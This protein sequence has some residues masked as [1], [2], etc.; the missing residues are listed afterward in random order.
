MR[1]KLLCLT[2][3]V[4][5]MVG[6]IPQ[7]ISTEAQAASG[8]TLYVSQSGQDS[9]DGTLESP[10]KTLNAARE[11]VRLLK[12]SGKGD[13]A[14]VYIRGG[15]YHLN[16][17]FILNELDSNT[18]FVAYD[19]EQVSIKGSTVLD[20]SRFRKV[21]DNEVLSHFPDHKVA[22]K[23]LQYNLNTHGIKQKPMNY[24]GSNNPSWVPEGYH[25]QELVVNDNRQ[26]VARYPNSGYTPVYGAPDW[27]TKGSTAQDSVGMS[28]R[29]TE[30]Q[31]RHWDKADRAMI[32]G[33]FVNGWQ[34][35]TLTI[36][37]V[38][39]FTNT[40]MANE[41][42]TS[43][44][45][46]N[47]SGSGARFY[48]FNLLEEL[49]TSGEYYVDADKGILYLYPSETFETDKIELTT[50][51]QPL[52]RVTGAKNITFSGINFLNGNNQGITITKCDNVCVRDGS[53]KNM[54]R[55]A[56][57]ISNSTNSGIDHMEIKHVRGGVYIT[58]CG[59]RKTLTPANCYCKN[60]KIS[61]YA[62]VAYT[63]A[64]RITD[65]VG[66][67][68]SN[69]EI[70][71][72]DHLAITFGGNEHIIEY[73]DIHD[74]LRCT[75]DAGAIYTGK[76]W[77][78]RGHKVRYNYIHD[79]KN[80]MNGVGS[81]CVGIYFDDGFCSADVYGNIIEDFPGIG[82][83]VSGG[84]D[85]NVYNNIIGSTKQAILAQKRFKEGTN[86]KTLDG[87]KQLTD[88]SVE[89]SVANYWQTNV[90]KTEYP[91]L[92]TILDDESKILLPTGNSIYNNISLNKA[93]ELTKEVVDNGVK[94]QANY[95]PADFETSVQP[96]ES[97]QF[98][99]NS[100][101]FTKIPEFKNIDF[102]NIGIK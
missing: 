61:E 13:T 39:P 16:R 95:S 86:Y 24:R 20:N 67:I 40:I 50:L 70:C 30:T 78:A 79:I 42:Y 85:F 71:D 84:K 52:V 75:T 87:Y 6:L 98:P 62:E 19:G 33:H 91:T 74:V 76:S 99:A 56:I 45:S 94:I 100:E 10:L 9:N 72:S 47:E 8:I 7:T 32:Y 55:M 5:F 48:I 27:G 60:T 101:V 88:S 44:T 1:L 28:F 14:T 21:T 97:Y 29:V 51:Q 89:S 90:W 22:E 59:D 17:S 25:P 66:N 12:E 53:I 58:N 80:E 102:S 43:D 93:F 73:N 83:F 11:K 49:D 92:Y 65:G 26:T 81:S 77:A 3:S 15:D 4:A 18:N 63:A 57:T 36:S 31:A 82:I 38:N 35:R 68:V 64:V 23:I 2:L 96:D 46:A 41:P 34:D 54:G 37:S 69:N